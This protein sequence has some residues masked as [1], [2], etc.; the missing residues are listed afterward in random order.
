MSQD[1]DIPNNPGDDIPNTPPGDNIPNTPPGDNIPN[2]PPGD[3]IPNNPPGDNIP[4]N[5]PGDNIPNNPGDDDSLIFNDI[6]PQERHFMARPERYQ[7]V[8]KLIKPK[9]CVFCHAAQH[10]PQF[11]TLCIHQTDHS[12]WLMNKY[13][14]NSGHTLVTPKRHCKDLTDL[15]EEEY[16]DLSH[17]LKKALQMVNDIYQCQGVNLGMNLGKVAGA[18]I[19]DHIH[20]HIIPR[21]YGDTNF[22]PLVAETKVIPETLEQTYERFKQSFNE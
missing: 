21:W 8:R 1:D 2:N 10:P 14:Y 11:K 16:S 12:T 5:P 17:L 13:P 3:N 6:W 18:G 9:G 15:S 7:Y 22:F 19:P 20:W 4:N